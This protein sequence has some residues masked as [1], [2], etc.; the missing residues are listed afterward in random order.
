MSGEGI[1]PDPNNVAA[2]QNAP[3]STT[4]TQVRS[5]LGAVQ[6]YSEFI[7]SLADLVEPMQGLLREGN[8]FE[9]G[10]ECKQAFEAVKSKISEHVQLHHFDLHCDTRVSVDVQLWARRFPNTN[11]TW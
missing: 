9:W 5:F 8:S 4:A 1:R 2:I 3:P 11:P 10:E 7:P 6:F